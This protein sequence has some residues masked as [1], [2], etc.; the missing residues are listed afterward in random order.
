M[1][2]TRSSKSRM[3]PIRSAPDLASST[4][5]GTCVPNMMAEARHTRAIFCLIPRK[6]DRYKFVPS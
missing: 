6:S 5:S 2:M 3:T 4:L 1:T